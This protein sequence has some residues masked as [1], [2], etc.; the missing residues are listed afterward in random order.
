MYHII[1]KHPKYEDE[2]MVCDCE[3]FRHDTLMLCVLKRKLN[4]A[5]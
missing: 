4:I 2:I 1:I 5:K 3:H